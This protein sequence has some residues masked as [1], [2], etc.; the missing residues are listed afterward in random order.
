MKAPSPNHWAT[1]EFL[2]LIFLGHFLKEIQV[3]S[4]Q[5]HPEVSTLSQPGKLLSV[6][7]YQGPP[8]LILTLHQSPHSYTS[9]YSIMCVQAYNVVE[10]AYNEESNV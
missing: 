4:L 10:I 3:L 9:I 5:M 2:L 1:K 6:S 7:Y 8:L